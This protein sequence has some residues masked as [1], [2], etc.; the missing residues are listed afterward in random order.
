MFPAAGWH[1]QAC[2]TID[3]DVHFGGR[4][5]DPDALRAAWRAAAREPNRQRRGLSRTRCHRF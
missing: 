2:W 5:I 1:V 3:A 4:D